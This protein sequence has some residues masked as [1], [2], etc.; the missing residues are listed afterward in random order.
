LP[1][2]AAI[3]G[4]A[5]HRPLRR[6]PAWARVSPSTLASDFAAVQISKDQSRHASS[7]PGNCS[8]PRQG[9]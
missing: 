9:H 8:G 4:F 2:S 5:A 1:S 3:A 7:R 6:A